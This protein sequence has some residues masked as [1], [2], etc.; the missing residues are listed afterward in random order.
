MDVRKQIGKLYEAF[1]L[2]ER[3]NPEKVQTWRQALSQL[4]SIPGGQYSEIWDGDAELIHQITVD[5]WNIFVASKS[6]D[7]C[8]L[9]GM[10]RHMKAMYRLLD[11]GLKDEVRHIKIWGSRDIGKTE[12]AKYLYEE[13]LHN[14]DTHVMLK[15]PQRISRFEEV[16]LAEYVCL[17]LEKAR[18]LSKTSKDTASRFLLVLDNVNESFDPIR[19]L[20]RVISSFGPGSRIITTTRNLQFSSTSPLPFQYE[21][22]GLEFSEAL[23]LFCLHAFE[24][25]HPFLGFED[26]S[27]RAVKLA[28]GFPLSLKR[29]G[30]RFSGRKKDEWEV[31]LFGYERSTVNGV[32]NPEKNSLDGLY[33][34]SSIMET[35]SSQPIS[36][37]TRSFEDLVGMNHR[38]QALSAL[39]EL[40]SDKEVRVVGIWGTG[41]IGKTTLSR[42]AYERISQQFHTHAFLENAQESSS[43][44]LEERF[45]SKA[46]QREALAVRNSKDCPEIMKSLI[47]HRKVLLIV[48]DVDNVKTLEEVFKITSWLVPGS[49]VI[50]TARDESFL[51][52]S[53]VKY[54]FEVKGLRFDQALQLF[55]QFA[56]KQKSPPVRFR[57]LSVRAIK[58]VGF[59]PLALKVTGSMLYRKKES[60]W[61]TILQCFEEKQNKGT[62]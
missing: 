24:Q 39:L 7:L 15:A 34:Y 29:L 12:F 20:A 54:I 19:K 33:E 38:M 14:F 28:G 36:S 61:E 53:G 31:I 52:A 5:I 11:L 21:V 35:F 62:I 23:Q 30:S 40:E 1:S 42:Y 55:Y 57:Q 17:R 47:Q 22:L 6:S 25:T 60:Y 2:H 48:D 44:C 46:I 37:T 4:V 26:L 49:R 58:L 8:G 32:I 41:G 16:R 27:C 9:V 43:S 3:E 51:L 56:F 59:L 50:V 13:I 45:L 10:D 18:T